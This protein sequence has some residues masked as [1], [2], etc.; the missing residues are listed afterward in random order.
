M[1]D[2]VQGANLY[3]IEKSVRLNLKDYKGESRHVDLVKVTSQGGVSVLVISDTLSYQSHVPFQ[4]LLLPMRI[5][6]LGVEAKNFISCPH[7]WNLQWARNADELRAG[8]LFVVKDHASISAQSPGIGPNIDEYGPRFYDISSMYEKRF[9][10]VINE[11]IASNKDIKS[12]H[13]EVFWV[14]NSAVPS[15]TVFHKMA[16]G[17]SNHKVCFK[18]VTKTGI[19]ELMA[20]HH[21]QSQSPYKLTSG[22]VGIITDSC[23]RKQAQ[24]ERYNVGVMHLASVVF[25][26][27]SKLSA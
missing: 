11:I 3:K 16:E 5:A 25:D 7:I 1:H 9:T 13:G 8:D 6:I 19:S 20:V 27:F 15:G 18:G 23:I 2:L 17:L 10:Q 12:T 26:A 14:N 21:R 24:H 22:M 4:T